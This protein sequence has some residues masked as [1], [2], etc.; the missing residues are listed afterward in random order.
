MLRTYVL[1]STILL[2]FAVDV[3]GQTNS[4]VNF[5]SLKVA[6]TGPDGTTSF[7]LQGVDS[8]GQ[9]VQFL[10]AD[11]AAFGLPAFSG[12]RPCSPPHAYPTSVFPN[13]ISV[14]VNESLTIIKFELTLQESPPVYMNQLLFSR[15]HDF[16]LKSKT[17]LYGKIEVKDK[18]GNIVA[19]DNDVKLEGTVSILFW[20]PYSGSSRML[21]DFKSVEYALNDPGL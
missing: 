16:Y 12:C 21:T 15:K 10:V 18:F 7:N 4:E 2:L 19:F 1:I 3:F 5:T 6:K 17:K 14:E 8:N 20:K 13:P 9:N 11:S